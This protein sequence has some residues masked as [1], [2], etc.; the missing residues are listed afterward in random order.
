MPLI[1]ENKY[2]LL[3]DSVIDYAIYTLDT[4]GAVRSWNRGAERCEG[5][6]AE[7]I[8]GAGFETFFVPE[9]R[10]EG[11]PAAMLARAIECGRHRNRHWNCGC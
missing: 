8:L 5:Y 7:D 3:V 10:A 4:D 2:R 11:L 9:D 6:G 1:E